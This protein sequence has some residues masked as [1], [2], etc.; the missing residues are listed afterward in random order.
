MEAVMDKP[1]ETVD[2]VFSERYTKNSFLHFFYFVFCV[3][4]QR[5]EGHCI[6][7]L[8]L[9]DFAGRVQYNNRTSTVAPRF[10]LK[11]TIAEA[12]VMWKLYRMEHN[13]NEW[14]YMSFTED[15][16]AYHTKRIKR[17]IEALPETFG[18]YK[19]LSKAES[20]LH[21][22]SPEGKVF[23]CEPTGIFTFKRGSHP[24]GMICD[25]ILRDPQVKL[26]FTQ[27]EKINRIFF[28]E[29]E[30]M[31]KETLHLVGTP[32]DQED[33]FAKLEE[34]TDYNSKRYDAEISEGIAW[35]ANSPMFNWAG[36]KAREKRIGAKAYAK[37]FRCM[38]VRG[39][40]GYISLQQMSLIIC[41]RLRNFDVLRPPVLKARNI[42]GGFDIGKKTH[43]SHFCVLAEHNNRL[44]Q[45]HSKFMDGWDYKD[46]VAYLEQ[47]ILAFNIDSLLYDDTRAEFEGFK[48]KGELPDGM[49]G[50]PFTVK[51]KFKMATELDKVVTTKSIQLINDDRQRRQILTVDSDLNA[52]ETSEGH[53]DAFFSLCLAVQAWANSKGEVA[54]LV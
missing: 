43:P 18:S 16:G 48:E 38:P 52:P 11:S 45:I 31:P 50:I 27:L 51:S 26:D 6:S 46:Q 5:V 21:Y 12:F 17:F 25:D 40:D 54:T 4:L 37:E 36:L 2:D 8:H 15:M 10:H 29:L 22:Q 24:N 14:L 33:L 53:G 28:E 30:Q 9:Q 49:T 39:A 7:P 44:V 23:V 35:W 32:Q 47:A 19:S 34:V 42:V 41:R 3:A 1:A 20:I 13:Y